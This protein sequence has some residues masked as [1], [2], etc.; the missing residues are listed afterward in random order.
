MKV[1]PS[2]D[3]KKRDLVNRLR[4]DGVLWLSQVALLQGKIVAHAAYSLV[5]I[6]EGANQWRYPAVG[7]IAVAPAF[8]RRGIGTALIQA[9]LEAVRDAGYGM[10]FSGWAQLVLSALRL[11]ACPAPRFH[12]RLGEAG[13]TA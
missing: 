9:G 7:P 5:T 13:R 11:S 6:S 12:H 8:Q 4:E 10:I 2:V 1:K 3:G